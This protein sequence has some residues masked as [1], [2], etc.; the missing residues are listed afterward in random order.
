MDDIGKRRQM[1]DGNNSIIARREILLVIGTLSLAQV[2][3][4]QF[5]Y[6]EIDYYYNGVVID[7]DG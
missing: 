1:A 2:V 4:L 6:S 5:N 7:S 3:K